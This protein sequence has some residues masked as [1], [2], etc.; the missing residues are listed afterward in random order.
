MDSG[1]VTSRPY[2]RLVASVFGESETRLRED[3]EPFLSVPPTELELQSRW[4][5]GDFGR[6][7]TSTCGQAVRIVQF[8]FWNHSAGPDFSNVVVLLGENAKRPGAIEIDID[9]RNWERHGHSEN[10]AYNDVVLHLFVEA[11]GRETFYTRTENHRNVVQVRLD[12]ESAD[13]ARRGLALGGA[14]VPDAR[15][16]R[17][18][19]PLAG[20]PADA[21]GQLLQSAARHRLEA[22]ARRLR[23]I[24]EIHGEREMVYQSVAQALGYRR[25]K[26]PMTVL[27]QRLPLE[28]L[29]QSGPRAEALLFGL[30]GFLETRV[31]ENA[32][33][34]TRDYLRGLWE[35]WWKCRAEFQGVDLGWHLAGARPV[36]HPQRRVAALGAFAAA[37][38][39]VFQLLAPGAFSRAKLAAI[40]ASLEHPYWNRHYT[41][42][43]A[44]SSKP[45]ALIGK[46]RVNDILANIIY[47]WVA[48]DNP[49]LWRDYLSI[50]GAL[51]NEKSRRA[52]ARLLGDRDDSAAF[53]RHL[54]QQQALLQIYDDFCRVDTSDCEDCPFP[55][56]L[57]Q[58]RGDGDG[59][60][61]G[62][63]LP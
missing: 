49:I 8:G 56:Q 20:M 58:W 57:R 40:L 61:D 47:P 26:L 3:T 22:K 16:G 24:A 62:D 25:N 29:R 63:C 1:S 38:P 36:N 43:S 27:A 11:P 46:D 14:G 17:C 10:P 19:P 23:R 6:D 44:A 50:R 21:V 31:F 53:T 34:D 4:F 30:A 35:T 52:T 59:D 55:E 18:A 37:S 54:Y 2:D 5:A 33:P 41:L 28:L 15:P 9:V 51:E 45:L 60:G 32:A 42:T 39:K 12:L 48:A 7:F 13:S